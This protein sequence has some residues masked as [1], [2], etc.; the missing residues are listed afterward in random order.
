M[1]I[2]EAQRVGRVVVTSNCS[3]MPEVAGEAACFVDPLDVAS[4]HGGFQRVIQDQSY[5]EALIERGFEN[6]RRFG[7][8]AVA[9]QYYR[10]YQSVFTAS[11]ELKSS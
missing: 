8:D 3:S 7:A 6:A 2:V 5:R 1:P 10:L 11:V 9:Q 4:I